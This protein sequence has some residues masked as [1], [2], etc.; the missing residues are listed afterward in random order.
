M[1]TLKR[2]A[3]SPR[4]AV[5]KGALIGY[6]TPLMAQDQAVPN[7]DKLLL[8]IT[9][10]N[11]DAN[12][13]ALALGVAKLTSGKLAMDA[14]MD[15]VHGFLDKFGGKKAPEMATA[16]A[17]E[18]PAKDGEGNALAGSVDPEST[19]S[20]VAEDDD[21]EEKIRELLQGKLD[22]QDLEMLLKLVRPEDAAAEPEPG[23]DTEVMAAS[24]DEATM[25]GD[26]DPA[27]KPVTQ[28]A[29][30]AAIAKAVKQT[31]EKMQSKADAIRFVRPWVGDIV[32]AMDS[33]ESVYKFA[34]EKGGVETKGVHPSA[35]KAMLAMVPKP[36]DAPRSATPILG[37]DAAG[38]KSFTERYPDAARMRVIG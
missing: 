16:P 1:P 32:V 5:V 20:F 24:P 33:A 30:D 34:L 29:M 25:T 12:K 2:V 9:A 18:P 28:P 35:F 31:E 38:V 27:M 26:G 15:D 23:G 36:G 22:P 37:M 19:D 13:K 21:L 10:K 4:A 14:D 17:A 7:F 3:L 8:K 11:Y 6:L